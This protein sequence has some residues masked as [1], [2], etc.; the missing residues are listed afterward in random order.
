MILMFVWMKLRWLMFIFVL[1]SRMDWK[2]LV[3]MKLVGETLSTW[4]V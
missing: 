1:L 4:G 3:K 2:H